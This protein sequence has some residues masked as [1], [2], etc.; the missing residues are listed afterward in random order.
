MDVPLPQ[1]VAENAP[2]DFYVEAGSCTRCCLV[3]GEA[4]DLLNDPQQPFQECY[5][6]RQP[7]TPAEIDQ[8]ISAISVSEMSALR[9]GGSDPT[10]IEK[11]RAA[12]CGRQCDQTSEGQASLRASAEAA[13][14]WRARA[15]Q[16]ERLP[17]EKRASWWRRLMG[18]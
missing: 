16:A 11:L 17:L 8:A 13:A 12:K 9:Y 6:R 2:G 1:R 18:W 5:F 15:A 4:P 7:Q 14:K 10:I 3:H